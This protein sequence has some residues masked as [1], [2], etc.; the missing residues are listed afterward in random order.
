MIKVELI[1]NPAKQEAMEKYMKKQFSFAG[2]SAPLRKSQ[3]KEMLKESKSWSTKEVLSEVKRYY[4][5]EKREYQYVA[6]DLLQQNIKRITYEELASLFYLVT[7][8]AW[9]DSVDSLR[10]VISRW[11]LLNPERFEQVFQYFTASKNFWNRRV[12]INLQLGYKEKT[13]TDNLQAAIIQ[14]SDTN[15]FFI[16]KAIG[17]SLRDY[18]KSNPAWVKNFISE[19]HN[20]S[21]LAIREGSKYL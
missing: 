18:S 13:Q 16:Q 3:S 2:V 11:C 20:L 1:Q 17:W 7:E 8:K 15:E 14:D 4:A 12:A 5:L 10:A 19:T 9:W 21:P 6:I